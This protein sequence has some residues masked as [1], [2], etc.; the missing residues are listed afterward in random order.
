[1]PSYLFDVTTEQGVERHSFTLD[2]DR[3]LGPQVTQVLEELR[4]R[5]VMLRGG[6]D[7]ELA[8]I[9]EGRELSQTQRPSQLGISPTRPV[10]L[11]MR[12]RVAAAASDDSLPRGVLASS[13]LGY[14]GALVAWVLT[15]FWTDITS[16]ISS[17]P[18]LDIAT[19]FLL[20][21]SVGAAVLGGMALRTRGPVLLGTVAGILVGGAGAAVGAAT[22]AL[23]PVTGSVRGFLLLRLLGWTLSGVL[24]AAC[25]GCY[26]RPLGWR[27]VGESALL[28]LLAGAIGGAV[29]ALPGPSELWQG[30][31]FLA[32][33]AGTGL[34][35][36]GPALWG[37]RAIVEEAPTHG[38]VP[39]VV[40]LREWPVHEGS[41]I[42]LG[43]GQI[44][45][46]DGQLAIYPPPAGAQIDGRS[47]A[48]PAFI[49]GSGRLTIDGVRYRIRVASVDG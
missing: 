3:P 43:Q 29:F 8:V 49:G 19:M 1:M 31:A 26:I 13:V 21:A 45:C 42:Q 36:G 48:Q 18:R 4:Q 14:L 23:L 5:G 25:T 35:V 39:S 47:V 11:R 46:Q 12:E 44:A 24:T 7:D 32:F 6:H 17:Y 38:L 22:V 20:G 33:G 34:A 10:Q 28:G 16:A 9:W 41:A 15:G 37:A 27:R 40:S 30:L 2:D